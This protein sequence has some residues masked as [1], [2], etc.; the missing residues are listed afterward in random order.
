MLWNPAPDTPEW[1]G[2]RRKLVFIAAVVVL[3]I[4]L[5]IMNSECLV[6]A[7]WL[8]A[9]FALPVVPLVLIDLPLRGEGRTFLAM[10]WVLTSY[11]GCMLMAAKHD[12][13]R[14]PKTLRRR[15]RDGLQ[16]GDDGSLWNEDGEPEDG[17][18]GE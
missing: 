3:F 7:A 13:R 12:G 9:A 8:I 4:V 5:V 16:D 6:C 1:G 2:I 11:C 18:A 10:A 14:H 17:E 15:R